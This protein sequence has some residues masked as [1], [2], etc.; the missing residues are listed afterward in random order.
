VGG[1]PL[2]E[3]VV[4]FGVCGLDGVVFGKSGGDVGAGGMR[5][6]HFG[7]IMVFWS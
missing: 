5:V 6:E 1:V 2:G 4:E 3:I 7:W